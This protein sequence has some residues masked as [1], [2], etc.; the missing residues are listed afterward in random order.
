MRAPWAWGRSPL[1]LPVIAEEGG[2]RAHPCLVHLVRA[3]NGLDSLRDFAEALRRYPPG[4]DHELVLAMKGFASEADAAPYLAEVADLAPKALFFADRG[5]DLGV[6]FECAARLRSGRY[7]FVNSHARPQVDGWMAKLNSALDRPGVGMTGATGCWSSSHSWLTYAMGLPSVYRYLMPPRRLTRDKILEIERERMG[8]ERRSAAEYLEARLTTIVRIPEELFGFEPFPSVHLRNTAF[9][10]NHNV[11]AAMRLFTIRHKM[12]TYA[13]ES[14]RDNMTKQVKEMGLSVLV[15][16]R[17]GVA[18]APPDWY[19]SRTLWQGDQE[20]LLVV[21]NQ[22]AF[23]AR[24]DAD[25]RRVLSA[26]GW[27]LHAAPGPPCPEGSLD[28]LAADVQFV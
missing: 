20:G 23:Y 15:V 2:S 5:F 1:T 11:L 16:D 17:D 3:A 19:R 4:I 7:C 13:L 14:G 25:R 6:Y 10:L 28:D 21:D 8:V 9:M 22:T 12:D 26:F 24:G 18:Y 27:G